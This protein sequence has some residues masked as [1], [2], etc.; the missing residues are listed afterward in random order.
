LPLSQFK[1]GGKAEGI[2][3]QVDLRRRASARAPDEVVFGPPFAPPECWCARL[4][5]ESILNHSSSRSVRSA[6][7]SRSHFPVLDQRSNRLNTVFH[8]PNSL[9]KSRHGTPV[10]RHQITASMNMRSSIGGRPI[11]QSA[12]RNASIFF[13]FRSSSFN[14]TIAP[15]DGT[16]STAHGKNYFRDRP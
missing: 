10:R 11:R 13:H 5:V 9:G 8:G 16:Q 7:N 15:I 14:R 6:R 2:D 1:V 4:I 3:D 12:V